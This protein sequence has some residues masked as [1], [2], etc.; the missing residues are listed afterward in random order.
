MQHEEFAEGDGGEGA[1]PLDKQVA[2][3]ERRVLED[4]IRRHDGSHAAAAKELGISE[5]TMS[6]RLSRTGSELHRPRRG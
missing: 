2:A 3:F 4:A 5:R 6:Y 1:L